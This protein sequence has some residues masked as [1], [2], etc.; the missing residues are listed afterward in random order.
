MSDFS[1]VCQN[2][3]LINLS[4]IKF[5][6]RGKMLVVAME[7]ACM[8]HDSKSRT[9]DYYMTLNVIDPSVTFPVRC[10]LFSK[11]FIN[12]LTFSKGDLLF[13]KFY[14]YYFIVYL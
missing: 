8:K 11:V 12:D 4:K 5:K 3:D 10:Y 14:V 9:G 13:G 7:N 1:Q 6:K 2:V